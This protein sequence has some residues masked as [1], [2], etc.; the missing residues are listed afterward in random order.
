MRADEELARLLWSPRHAWQIIERGRERR[1]ATRTTITW[2]QWTKAREYLRTTSG[3]RSC[4]NFGI[5]RGSRGSRLHQLSGRSRLTPEYASCEMWLGR[6]PI[7]A[8]RV[9]FWPA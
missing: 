5:A 1:S 6:K 9:Y 8:T 3:G 4:W 7:Q 2:S